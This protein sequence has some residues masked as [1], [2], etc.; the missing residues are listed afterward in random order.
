MQSHPE[1]SAERLHRFFARRSIVGLEYAV[2]FC[3]V[4]IA[5]LAESGLLGGALSLG[6]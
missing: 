1:N 3:L 6:P 5:M 4:V 2:L